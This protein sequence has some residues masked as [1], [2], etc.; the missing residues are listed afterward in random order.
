MNTITQRHVLLRKDL[1]PSE[2]KLL[3]KTYVTHLVAGLSLGER[4]P[5]E[6]SQRRFPSDMSAGEN[7][8]QRH[9][10]WE[11]VMNV[12]S[13]KTFPNVEKPIML[14]DK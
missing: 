8:S 2:Q 14:E 6:A 1:Q 4:N 13:G 12:A 11:R 3:L 10:A 5:D 7:L 9:V